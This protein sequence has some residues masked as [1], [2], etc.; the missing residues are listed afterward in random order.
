MKNT[1]CDHCA[2][3]V[4]RP[5]AEHTPYQVRSRHRGRVDAQRL[6]PACRFLEAHWSF[7]HTPVHP[8]KLHR[9][10][11]PLAFE[12]AERL[13]PS[14]LLRFFSLAS[15]SA[16]PL[17][18]LRPFHGLNSRTQ[19]CYAS[20][21]FL[22]IGLHVTTALCPIPRTPRMPIRHVIVPPGFIATWASA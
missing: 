13:H 7:P 21:N 2:H 15:C 16:L 17:P 20:A 14:W 6:G 9:T 4:L 22:Y 1:R 10:T 8:T 12:N 11:L 3:T 19:H 5:C 18:Q